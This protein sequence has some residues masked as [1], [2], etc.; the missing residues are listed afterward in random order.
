MCLSSS[1]TTISYFKIYI[2]FL[3]VNTVCCHADNFTRDDIMASTQTVDGSTG[4]HSVRALVSKLVSIN[5][6]TQIVQL[7]VFRKN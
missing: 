7:P 6:L 4:Q 5:G 3:L 2:L 1:P